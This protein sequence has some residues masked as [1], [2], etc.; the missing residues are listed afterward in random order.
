VSR[1]LNE[2]GTPKWII[3]NKEDEEKLREVGWNIDIR[4]IVTI[5]DDVIASWC[6]NNSLY[7][8]IMKIK[9]LQQ[10]T[11]W[12]ITWVLRK[13][14]DLN[15]NIKVVSGI[16]V[17][18]NWWWKARINSLSTFVEDTPKSQNS[19]QSLEKYYGKERLKEFV[20]ELRNLY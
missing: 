8:K 12:A 1:K 17:E 18:K 2:K 3:I 13:P 14:N 4:N 11:L 5:Y 7:K 20:I 9:N 19:L 16:I 15:E 6:T 10:K